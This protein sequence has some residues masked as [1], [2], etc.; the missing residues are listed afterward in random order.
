MSQFHKTSLSLDTRTFEIYGQV[1]GPAFKY[2]LSGDG[3]RA[4]T[5]IEFN[6]DIKIFTVSVS[7]AR[8]A[9]PGARIDDAIYNLSINLLNSQSDS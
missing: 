6:E 2:W 8:T 4:V 1:M 7:A 3:Q 9:Y 5:F